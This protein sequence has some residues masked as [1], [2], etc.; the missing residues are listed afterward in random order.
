[1]RA[2]K[3]ICLTFDD[4]PHPVASPAILNVLD[5]FK[6]KA[7]FFV[8]GERMSRHPEHVLRMFQEGHE[9][10]NHTRTHRRL[11]QL[12]D[13][14][15]PDERKSCEAEFKYTTGRRM[16]L[17]RPPGM[18]FSKN[19]LDIAKEMGYVTV[20]WNIGAK[21]YYLPPDPTALEHDLDYE[22]K[23]SPTEVADI[24]LK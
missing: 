21:D 24:V 23:G 2:R 1:T 22:F 4:G 15:I 20:G 6:I 17:M 16:T 8:V 5:R 19:V 13:D 14:E 12:T 7:T 3:E 11:D 9:I 18:R 10:G